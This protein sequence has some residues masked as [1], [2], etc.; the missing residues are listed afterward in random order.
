MIEETHEMTVED[1]EQIG[2]EEREKRANT[3]TGLRELADL[4]EE[5]DGLPIPH[6]ISV[7]CFVEAIELKEAA[8]AMP[9]RAEKNAEGSFFELRKELGAGTVHYMVNVP[10]EEVC[11]R[12]QV[13]MKQVVETK[14]VETGE[15]V[16]E[17]V[18]EWTCPDSLLAGEDEGR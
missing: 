17:P 1:V 8:R 11:E 15:M 18:Y 5:H 10:R 12:K 6:R 16:E 3:V 4:L 9:G 2:R 7:D 13:G 14:V